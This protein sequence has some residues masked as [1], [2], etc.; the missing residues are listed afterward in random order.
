[1]TTVLLKVTAFDPS[2]RATPTIYIAAQHIVSIQDTN[3]SG[4][5]ITTVRGAYHVRQSS[6]QVRDALPEW[7]TA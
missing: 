1:M 2:G 4:C 5:L 7:G 6:T 3:P